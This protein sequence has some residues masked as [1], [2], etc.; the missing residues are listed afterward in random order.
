MQASDTGV[1]G[2]TTVG[3]IPVNT[4][5]ITNPEGQKATVK[6]YVT[7]APLNLW[8]WDCH[9]QWGVKITTKF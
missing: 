2:G 9:S 6:L 4:I 7:S 5:L 3:G 1:L 8:G